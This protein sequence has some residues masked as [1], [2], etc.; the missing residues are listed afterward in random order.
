[1]KTLEDELSI[2]SLNIDKRKVLLE[3]INT[4]RYCIESLELDEEQKA[5]LL[6]LTERI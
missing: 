6:R 1:M 2:E 5:K 4:V 3:E